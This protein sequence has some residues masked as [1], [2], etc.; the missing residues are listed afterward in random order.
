M[1]GPG[2]LPGPHS[3]PGARTLPSR[4]RAFDGVVLGVV[5]RLEA[6]WGAELGLVEF[7]VEE[8][9]LVPDDWA[10]QA[11]PLASLVRGSGTSPTR[12]VLF[13]RPIELRCESRAEL[14]AMVSRV[15]VEQV[16]EL[17]ER[18]PEE[19]DPDYEADA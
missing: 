19:I 2:V 15:L 12:L 5:R 13:R 9:P 14:A 18:G 3:P 1:R 11:V 8:A 16:A 17:L 7:A 6:Q 4:R 10:A